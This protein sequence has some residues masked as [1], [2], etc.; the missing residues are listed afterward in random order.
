MQSERYAVCSLKE[1]AGKRKDFIDTKKYSDG[2]ETV[3]PKLKEHEGR[4][5]SVYNL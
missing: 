1:K 3:A 5:I 2:G 4:S